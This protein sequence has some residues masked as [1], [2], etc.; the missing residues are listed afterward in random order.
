[1]PEP[2]PS[3]KDFLE[4]LTSLVEEHLSNEQFGVSELAEAVNMSRSN[5]LRKV[6]KL[7][8]LSVSQFIRVGL[9]AVLR[10]IFPTPVAARRYCR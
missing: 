4:Q 5:L 6:N 8:K 10:A 7:T 9:H 3:D 1:M 2:R